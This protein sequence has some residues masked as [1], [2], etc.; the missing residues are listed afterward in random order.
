M[1]RTRG[2][3]TI[4]LTLLPRSSTASP[5][6]AQESWWT[7]L[8]RLNNY[9]GGMGSAASKADGIVPEYMRVLYGMRNIRRLL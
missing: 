1:S 8:T 9:G 5:R 2:L 7:E 3:R 4:A 6:R